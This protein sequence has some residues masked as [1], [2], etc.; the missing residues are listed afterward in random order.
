MHWRSADEEHA[1]P[2]S[3]SLSLSLRA[4]R[5][6]YFEIV[7]SEQLLQLSRMHAHAKTLSFSL[8]QS[9]GSYTVREGNMIEPCQQGKQSTL[10]HLGGGL[11]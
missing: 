11:L 2:L 5:W 7:T 8:S 3:L 10:S 6:F 9:I 4:V 1:L